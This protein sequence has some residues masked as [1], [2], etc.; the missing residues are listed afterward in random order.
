MR[1]ATVVIAAYNAAPWLRQ[2]LESVAS[3]Q[4]PHGWRGRILLGIDAC[5][6]TLMV[7][8]KLSIPGLTLRYFP[9]RVGPYVIFNSLAC[10]LARDSNVLVRFDADDLML[11]DYLHRQLDILDP[12]V[13]N[14][15]Q[16]WSCYTGPDLR[17]L[18]APVSNGSKTRADGRRFAPSDGQFL[19]TYSAWNRL[20]GFQPWW[21]HADTEFL[22]R[23]ALSSIKRSVVPQH[24]YIRRIHTGSLTQSREMGYRSA[25]RDYYAS[26]IAITERRYATDP[27]PP[28]RP[29]IAR[30]FSSG[31][32]LQGRYVYC[33]N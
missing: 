8:R 23:A 13:P 24:L 5:T 25:M 1:F 12:Y 19:M 30:S 33:H 28:I 18:S 21:C 3:Q 20:G 32:I 4:L 29:V 27:P 9:S 31:F 16:T 6:A 14:I 10:S 2:C 7:A 22:K 17:P 26:Q 11:N 15:T